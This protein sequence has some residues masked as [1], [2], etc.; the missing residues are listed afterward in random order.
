M[1][2][3]RTTFTSP[4][5]ALLA[6][7]RS[8]AAFEQRFGLSTAEFYARY[9]VGALGDDRDIMEWAADYQHY[10]ALKAQLESKLESV[11]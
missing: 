5:E 9:Q 6:L 11:P 4:L 8:L 1:D 3:Q 10:Q 2:V 7:T